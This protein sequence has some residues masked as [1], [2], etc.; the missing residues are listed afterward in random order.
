MATLIIKNRMP[1]ARRGNPSIAISPALLLASTKR[2]T[3]SLGKNINRVET[4][5]PLTIQYFRR[6][7]RSV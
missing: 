5:S 1:E 2:T 3:N 7:V 6:R 4:N